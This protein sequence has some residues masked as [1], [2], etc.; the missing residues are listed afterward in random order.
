MSSLEFA[1]YTGVFIFLGLLIIF[2]LGTLIHTFKQMFIDEDEIEEK[3]EEIR[4]LK[5][6]IEKLTEK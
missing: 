3:D 1:Y 5:K 2:L 6:T 4:K